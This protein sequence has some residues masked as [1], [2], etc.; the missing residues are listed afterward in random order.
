MQL[1]ISP[2]HICESHRKDNVSTH[3]VDASLL[4]GISPSDAPAETPGGNLILMNVQR[5]TT[6]YFHLMSVPVDKD[7]T[8]IFVKLKP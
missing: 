3:T 6:L 8:A 2:H 1:C 5:H 4:K 7:I